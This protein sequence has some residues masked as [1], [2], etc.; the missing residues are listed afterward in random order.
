[1][2][3]AG[4]G[5][6]ADQLS[7]L[8]RVAFERFTAD[9]IG[10]LLEELRP[11]EQSLDRDSPEASMIR[12]TR[13]DYEKARRVPLD[14]RAEMAHAAALGEPVWRE[15]RRTSDFGLFLP[16]LEQAIELKKRYIECFQP[17]DEP[18]DALLDDYEPG[19]KTAEVRAV[20]A[21]LRDGLV[22][23]VAEIGERSEAVDDS[24]LT[25]DFPLA[26][27]QEVEAEILHAFGFVDE[28]W[29]V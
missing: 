12:V 23:L 16:Y 7:T 29:R 5:A 3:P 19:M 11:H 25:G 2:P 24:A 22:P 4:A 13:R 18:Y 6:R 20:F 14:L 1:M 17:V 21:E 27:Q 8:T 10:S 28:E 9:E 15:A 26:R